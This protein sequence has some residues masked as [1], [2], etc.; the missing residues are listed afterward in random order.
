MRNFIFV[1]L[2]LAILFFLVRSIAGIVGKYKS[3]S[4]SQIFEKGYCL[5]KDSLY[6]FN[7]NEKKNTTINF[8]GIQVINF[9]ATWCKPCLSEM[10]GLEMMKANYPEIMVSLI[11]FEEI[12][13]QKKTISFQKIK[14]PAYKLDDTTI[15]KKPEIYPR[16]IILKNGCVVRDMYTARDW[17]SKEITDVLDSL[18]VS[19]N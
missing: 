13:L 18:F 7:I 3:F 12:E 6:L 8:K 14:L 5:P 2:G 1:V 17:Q 10:P 4:N 9:W 11:S 19:K 16:T 15:F